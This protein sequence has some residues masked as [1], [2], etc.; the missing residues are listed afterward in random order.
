[1]AEHMIET[2]ILLRYDTLSN[3][4]NSTVILKQGEAAIA[5]AIF[6]YT[7]EGTNHRP[8][9]TP[10]AVGIKVGDGYHRFSEL[11]W[12]Q[13]VA[14]D[15]YAWAK[16][17]SKPTYTANEIQ[18]LVALIQ[19]CIRDAGGGSGGEVTVEA[20]AYRLYY[21]DNKYYLQSKGA[22]DEDWVTDQ[23]NY[24]DLG[25]L[26][27]VLEWLAPGLEDYW[28]IGSFT[29]VKII[30]ALNNLTYNDTED[31]S[32]VVTAVDQT[33]GLISVTRKP[34]LAANLSGILSVDKG[35]TGRS[36]LEQ[37]SVLVGNGTNAV[38]FIPIEDTLEDNNNF[39]TNRVIKRYIDN[40]T[41]GLTGAMHYI[42]EATVEI[43]NGTSVNPRINGYNFANAQYGDV[44][45][46]NNAEYVWEGVWRLLGDEGSYAV[47][48]SI[49]N[50]DIADE[51]NIAQS[52]IEGLT[53]DLSNKVDKEDGKGLS[54]ND[55][56]IE[57]KQKLAGIEDSAQRN[58]IEHVYVNGAEAIPTIIDGRPNSL[59]L[60]VSALTPEEE[61]KISGI[62]AGA[63]V[64][65]IEHIFLNSNELNIGIVKNLA[66]SVNIILTEFT[67][68]EK[69]KLSN[70][71][72]L[73]QENK[74]EKIF[75]NETEFPPN[76]EKE[77]HVIIDE[78]ALNLQVIKGARTPLGNGSYEDVSI[79]QD[80]KLELARIAAT[81]NIAD[82]TQ[83]ANTYIILDCGSST[84]V[85]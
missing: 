4:M 8:E 69:E 65:R 29:N 5:A 73:A 85:L 71:E 31:S 59:S 16:Q 15:V 10:P 40:L 53:V 60:R 43:R 41:A 57:E 36:E 3:W 21:N 52:K 67:D 83:T 81:G 9:N 80:K 47:K 17:Q 30:E 35:G 68:A 77:V 62:E 24:I 44:I 23:L 82:I 63:Q 39:T 49:T 27:T 84:E 18:G 72:N 78:A 37:G 25:S 6:D 11:P 26:A 45:T 58:I 66:K 61:E 12:V 2:R 50:A 48:G 46:F 34:L 74:I 56:T 32:K 33:N 19:Q 64:N 42:G 76:S 20:R 54:S 13:G 51:A 22:N 70:I 7:I 14:G 1:M 75:F 38:S 55:Y 79:T 28:N